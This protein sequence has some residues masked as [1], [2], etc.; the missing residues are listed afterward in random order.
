M[1]PPRPWSPEP[2]LALPPP[3]PTPDDVLAALREAAGPDFLS[4]ET[5]LWDDGSDPSK[6]YR[7]VWLKIRRD[8]L[9]P[10]VSR[11][12]AIHYPHL[13]VIGATDLG[14]TIELPYVFRILAGGPNTDILVTV[15]AV[16]PKADPWVDTLTDL[17]PGILLGERE[18]QEMMGVVVRNI[19]DGR[20]MFLPEDFPE[21]V[22]P[23]RRDETA[24]PPSMVRPLW[25][26]GRP[27][28]P[29]PSAPA[30]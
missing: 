10:V 22:Y 3:V 14:D 19:P 13:V 17:I 20:R 7:Q 5:R 11:L 29:P 15:A 1:N 4:G 23:W 27:A 16:L 18:K 12:I 2:R 26:E 9:R 30:T 6:P 8:S 24:P 21:G 25:A 28:S